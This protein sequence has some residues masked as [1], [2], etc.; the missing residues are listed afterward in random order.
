M[1]LILPAQVVTTQ[2]RSCLLGKPDRDKVPTIFTGAGRGGTLPGTYENPTLPE[3]KQ[4]LL[5]NHI[6]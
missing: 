1:C 6:V 3:E 2:V 5:I 4:V